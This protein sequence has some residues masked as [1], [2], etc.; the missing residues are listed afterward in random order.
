MRYSK[1][2]DKQKLEIID[3]KIQKIYDTICVVNDALEL[4][5]GELNPK[6]SD[7]FDFLKSIQMEAKHITKLFWM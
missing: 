6:V 5:I 4:R 2:T 1:F 7:C 3:R